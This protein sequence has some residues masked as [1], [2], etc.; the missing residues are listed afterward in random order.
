MVGI[1]TTVG[2]FGYLGNEIFGEP[3]LIGIFILMFLGIISLKNGG[4]LP[5]LIMIILPA[6]FVMGSYLI[7]DTLYVILIMG[8]AIIIAMGLLS[9]WR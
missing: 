8:V 5:L 7:P 2:Q 9:L 4:G 1:N 6:I 3:V